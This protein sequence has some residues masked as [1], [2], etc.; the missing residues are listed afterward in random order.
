MRHVVIAV[1]G[2]AALATGAALFRFEVVIGSRGNGVP[3]AYRLDRWTGDVRSL[4]PADAA[5]GPGVFDGVDLKE[6]LKQLDK[7]K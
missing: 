6:A 7:Q 2:V 3:P 1:L 4:S 5:S